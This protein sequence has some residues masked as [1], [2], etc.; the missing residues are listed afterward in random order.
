MAEGSVYGDGGDGEAAIGSTED[1]LR[2]DVQEKAMSDI[3]T[4]REMLKRAGIEFREEVGPKD[5]YDNLSD[6]KDGETWI[7][8]RSGIGYN[9]AVLFFGKDGNLLRIEGTE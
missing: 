8:P 7:W 2:T 1:L 4:M 5:A 6:L 9:S 3:E